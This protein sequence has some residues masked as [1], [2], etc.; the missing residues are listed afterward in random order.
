MRDK[1]ILRIPRNR[2]FSVT[3]ASNYSFEQRQKNRT[4]LKEF[5]AIFFFISIRET[6]MN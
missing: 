2:C 6:Y 1:I 3:D 5:Q 4:S